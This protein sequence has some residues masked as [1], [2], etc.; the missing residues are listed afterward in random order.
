M[1]LPFSRTI[2]SWLA[3]KNANRARDGWS[4]SDFRR[5]MVIAEWAAWQQFY[6]PIDV[7]NKIILDVG[8]GEGETALFYLKHG[9]REVICI[10]SDVQSFQILKQNSINH[11]LK[12]FNK[13]FEIDDLS[14]I[15]EFNIDFM[16]IDIEGYEQS[17]LGSKL[18]IPCVC[19]VHGLQLRDSFR[20]EGWRIAYAE[21]TH[22]ESGCICY[23]YW[24]PEPDRLLDKILVQQQNSTDGEPN[25]RSCLA[26]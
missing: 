25:L 18:S 24:M 14:L 13:R 26:E 10:E 4:F 8:A 12:G 23:A 15:Q 17:L 9:A 11:P 22:K 5:E 21:K 16:K 19:E 6:L 3:A 7:R 20:N 1:K 2:K